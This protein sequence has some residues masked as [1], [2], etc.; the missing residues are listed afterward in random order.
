MYSHPNGNIPH[1]SA[2]FRKQIWQKT[3]KEGSWMNSEEIITCP[4]CTSQR[5]WKD[6]FL[7]SNKGKMQRYICRDCGRRFS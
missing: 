2:F 7:Y 5:T 1:N 3:T 6:G 4:E